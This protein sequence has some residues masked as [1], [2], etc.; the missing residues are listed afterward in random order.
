MHE[1]GLL[2][3]RGSLSFLEKLCVKSFVDAGH[4]T[5]L[6]SYEPIGGVPDGVEMRDAGEILPE[7]G[8]LTHERTGSPALH[9]DLFRYKL[10]EKTD[11]MIWADTDAY[12]M[13]PFTTP[14]GHFYGWESG[15][16]INGGVLGLPKDSATL[17]ALLDYTRDEFAIPRWYG[18]EYEAELEAKRPRAIRS[19]R[20]ISPG[21]S[22]ARMRSPIS[23]IRRVRRAL[24][25]RATGSIPSPS[26]TGARW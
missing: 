16:H 15:H 23:C 4:P 1:I 24:P 2:W 13:R 21:A 10:L 19:M 22:G 5:I 6:Y 25:C 7:T 8:F 18:P 17:A 20:A 9:S 3:M 12:C 26:A 11:N 14:N